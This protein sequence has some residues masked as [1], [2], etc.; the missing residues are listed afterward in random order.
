MST[1][2]K[3]VLDGGR[4]LRF[5][6]PKTVSG[7]VKQ[8]TIAQESVGISVKIYE[9][10]VPDFIEEALERLYGNYYSS[11]NHFV[12]AGKIAR[13]SS[14][15]ERENGTV[16]SL[17]LFRRDLH[18]LTV[19][20]EVISLTENQIERFTQNMFRQYP[21]VKVIIFYAIGST[22]TRLAYP[23][24][25]LN[26]LEDIVVNLPAS[27][28]QFFSNLSKG[29]RR[30]LRRYQ[31]KL[32]NNFPAASYDIWVDEEIREQDIHE[33]A[34]LNRSR[35]SEKNKLSLISEDVERN[36]FEQARKSGLVCTITI[37]GRVCAG[38][39]CFR[40]GNN[41]FLTVIAHDS[42]FDAYSLGC[43]CCTHLI[44]RCI[45]NA[46]RE[47][48]FLWGRYEYKFTLSGV[49]LDLNH[50][51]IYRSFFDFCLHAPLASRA[52]MNALKRQ[53]ILY[54]HEAKKTD[55]FL[56]RFAIPAWTRL[57]RRRR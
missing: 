26:Y 40:T 15:V 43:L 6:I 20:N 54:L 5:A 36:L 55:G 3:R 32:E 18:T 49:Q 29:T 7:K 53:L 16:V 28:D 2:I 30:N 4:A 9:N 50:V 51:L 10:E 19:L 46:G 34:N 22:I 45:A 31:K 13:A 8:K 33:I 23:Y 24:Q 25:Q 1:E 17:I 56:A 35:M 39:I 42:R 12:V 11:L 44:C 52:W 14:Y 27:E 38:A 57:R 37:D 48:H 47:F 21:E 41:Y